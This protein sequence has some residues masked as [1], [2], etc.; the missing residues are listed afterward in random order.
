MV[1][2]ANRELQRRAALHAALGDVAR[3]S[4]VDAL[5][6]SDFSPSE[7]GEL[8]G[9]ESNLLAHHLGVLTDVGLIER[10]PSHGDRRRRYLRLWPE[11]LDLLDITAPV[12]AT[13][14]VF[15]CTANSARSQLAAALWNARH[16]VPATSAGTEPAAAV[17][18]EAIKAARRRGLDL[19]G[20]KPEPFE[21]QVGS[22]DLIVTVCDRAHEQLHRRPGLSGRWLHWS[23]ADPALVGNSKAFDRA[24]GEL[25]QRISE[26]APV[27]VPATSGRRRKAR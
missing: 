25:D 12:D 16:D 13:G 11:A 24:A 23:I 27:V 4:I 7:L 6:L 21:A 20:A 15:V 9:I 5:A 10:M 18:P 3:L 8:L 19:R 17:H 22:K 26:V 1:V 14:V 2:E